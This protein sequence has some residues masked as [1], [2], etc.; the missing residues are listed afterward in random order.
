MRMHGQE[1]FARIIIAGRMPEGS[2]TKITSF[3]WTPLAEHQQSDFIGEEGSRFDLQRDGYSLEFETHEQ[4]S[5]LVRTWR[6]IEDTLERGVA[7]PTVALFVVKKYR[8]V[9]QGIVTLTFNEATLKLDSVDV[10]RKEF[11][12]WKWS[13]RA[14]SMQQVQSAA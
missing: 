2:F 3:N 6:E 14:R 12:T 4:D 9:S 7:L 5:Q 13:G 8:D 10:R 11:V 1:E